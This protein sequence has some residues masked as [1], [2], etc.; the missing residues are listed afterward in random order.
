LA[1]SPVVV[2]NL[3]ESLAMHPSGKFVYAA[4]PNLAV[5]DRDSTTGKLA[6]RG[7]LNTFK[8]QLALNPAGTFLVASERDS[9]E[10][11]EFFVAGNGDLMATEDRQPV[12]IPFAVASD[13]QGQFFAITEFTNAASN[14]GGLSMLKLSGPNGEYPKTSTA[15]FGSGAVPASVAFEPTGKFVY[16]VF[17][18]DGTIAGFVLDRSSGKLTPIAAKPFTTGDNPDSLTIVQPQ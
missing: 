6:V 4:T 5:L 8:R 14:S 9:N 12:L 10:I 3:P 2:E 1:G 17:H 11:S 16:A 7:V 15:P 18:N 13:P